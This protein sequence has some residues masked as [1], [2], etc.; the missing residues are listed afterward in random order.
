MKL[1]G[2]SCGTKLGRR[3]MGML[4]GGNTEVLVKEALMGAEELGVDVEFVRLY[5]LDIRACLHC[6]T[7]LTYEKGADAC[8]IKDDAPFL[9][10]RI[11]ECD[12][13]ILGAPVYS[14]TPPGY[15][16]LF[17]DRMLGPK[18]DVAFLLET[19]KSGGVGLSGPQQV[20]D[21]RAFKSRVGALISVG[22][23][24]TPHWLSFGLALL[25]TTTFPPQINLVD[26]MQVNSTSLYGHVV[27]NEK[28]I[29][30]AR[31][32]GRNVAEAM[33]KPIEEVNWMGDE[34]GICPVCHSNLLIVGKKN[35]VVCPICGIRGELKVE[36]DEIIV[37]F[38][39]EEQKRSRLTIA[40]KREHWVELNE[41][42]KMSLQRPD[43]GQIP[44]RLE[45]YKGYREVKKPKR[46]AT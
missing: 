37:T 25:H 34:P 24:S 15:L 44:K 4:I 23:A 26:Q 28:A 41:D 39:E 29:E 1:L 20:I 16:K 43:R 11:M 2:L 5:D 31:M 42:F 17:E 46:R 40:G 6:R 13:L 32:L 18:A 33:K 30:R 8:V 19:K 10:D 14:L 12:G 9:Y 36:G 38:S 22:G 3:H 7:C 27:L 35:P 45:K 21:E